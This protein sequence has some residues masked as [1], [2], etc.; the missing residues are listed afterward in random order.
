MALQATK[1]S[2]VGV[3]WSSWK[4]HWRESDDC[5]EF[6]NIEKEDKMLGILV[7]GKL[8][9]GQQPDRR[10]RVPASTICEWRL[11]GGAEPSEDPYKT[12]REY[13]K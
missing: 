4:E 7:V 12:A 10:K 8:T 11:D 1:Y 9:G 2:D 5:K 6:L 3:Y 13:L